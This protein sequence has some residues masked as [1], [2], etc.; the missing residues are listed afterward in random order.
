MKNGWKIEFSVERWLHLVVMIRREY[1][2]ITP[3]KSGCQYG[4]I[5][6]AICCLLPFVY[7]EHELVV[8]QSVETVKLDGSGRH[9][10]TGL[11]NRRPAL[12]LA[13]FESSFYWVDENGLWQVPQ[14]QPNQK[15]LIWKATLPILAVY[16]ELQQPQGTFLHLNYSIFSWDYHSFLH[17][18]IHF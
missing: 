3:L 11:F 9:S 18:V 8:L 1:N 14:N 17:L 16:H 12:S 5:W 13:V 15:Q 2:T 10:F 7:S 4:W 6:W